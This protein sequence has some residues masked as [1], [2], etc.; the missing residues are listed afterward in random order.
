MVALQETATRILV[1]AEEAELETLRLAFR[2]RPLNY[3]R[4]DS[5]Q[6]FKMSGGTQGWDGYR[7][8]L[9]RKTRTGGEILRG[10]K[11]EVLA[12]C[13]KQKF[14]VDATKLLASPYAALTLDALPEKLIKADYDLDEK[15][16]TAIVEWLRHGMGIAHFAVNAGKTA[17]FAG[18][19]AYVK[20]GY[21]DA[22]FLYYTPSER[23]VK[24]SCAEL[25]RFLPDWDIT[26]FGGGG[27]RDKSG[28]DMVVCT[29]AILSRNFEEL[30]REGWFETFIGV[31]IDESHH[32]QS[33][34]AEQVLRSMA[35][36]FR[37][38]ASDS[39]KESDPDKFNK[40]VGLCGPVRCSV[41][42][43]ELIAK[44]RS[45]KPHIYLVDVKEWRG[46]YEALEH[47]PEL[48][49][50]AWTLADGNW[51]KGAYLGP[52]YVLTENGKMKVKSRN[53]FK[54]GH[55]E[56][57][58]VIE[59]E[60]NVHQ[61]QLESG[62]KIKASASL[63]LLNR[64]YDRAIIRFKER[65]EM[66]KQW[67]RYYAV[68][69]K[70]PTVVVATRTTHVIIL[71]SLLKDAVGDDM[72]RALRSEHSTSERDDAFAWFKATAGAVLV[73]SIV[74]EGVSINEIKAGVIADPIVDW[75]VA[76]QI[77]G[78]FIRKKAENEAHL[79]WFIDRQH[80]KYE[81][82]ATIL[83]G[84]LQHLEGYRFY[85]PV[86]T[87]ESISS[88]TVYEGRAVDKQQ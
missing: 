19:A 36:F 4:A 38:A 32:A 88:A 76:R 27:K 10:R 73:T 49:S 28:K 33:P 83:F 31:M 5:Y 30:L 45:A 43:G 72:V 82:N 18:A 56:R 63:T 80:S 68:E 22:R 78:R 26:Q 64:R 16:R 14:A 57:E 34:T 53:R 47:E 85:H 59:T 54:N 61:L 2:Y 66:I 77:I 46:R 87:P 20:Q 84:K 37:M 75:E 71:E 55:W 15:Q 58:D 52:V 40:I 41:T 13:A 9:L 23:L 42:S 21:P 25:K 74:K 29:Q 44:G 62:E 81:R 12:V 39:M 11:D 8:P 35:S 51:I 17:T 48:N 86:T 60:P 67:V 79:T 6:V 1:T 50:T 3:Y 24:Q 65:N 69:N 7:Y 70:W